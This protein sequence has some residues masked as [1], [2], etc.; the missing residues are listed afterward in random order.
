MI[1][2]TRNFLLDHA[3]PGGCRPP[4]FSLDPNARPLSI[5]SSLVSGVREPQTLESSH[6]FKML[7]LG[8][9]GRKTLGCKKPEGSVGR[10]VR[11]AEL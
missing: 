6:Y 11:W 2:A 1:E 4:P 8:A 7:N 9:A 3:S 10:R 5:S